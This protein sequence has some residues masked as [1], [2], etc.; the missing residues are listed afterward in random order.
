MKKKKKPQINVSLALK[1]LHTIYLFYTLTHSH[2]ALPPRLPGVSARRSDLTSK[3]MATADLWLT[4][5]TNQMAHVVQG[6]G[7]PSSLKSH[8][9]SSFSLCVS[10]SSLLLVGDGFIRCADSMGSSSVGCGGADSLRTRTD[11]NPYTW[12]YIQSKHSC[13]CFQKKGLKN[14]IRQTDRSSETRSL[15]S[16]TCV[17][18]SD[19]RCYTLWS[20]CYT[21][22]SAARAPYTHTNTHTCAPACIHTG[23]GQSFD[24]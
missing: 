15:H 11:Q 24:Q 16:P 3:N 23:R 9:S 1:R 12:N 22:P 4:L 19:Q 17:V 7:P 13:L 8:F 21:C 5:I 20:C 10:L 2:A 14:I 18:S 6:G